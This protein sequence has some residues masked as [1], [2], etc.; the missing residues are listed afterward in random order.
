MIKCCYFQGRK[1]TEER[2]TGSVDEGTAK[3]ATQSRSS[4]EGSKMLAAMESMSF[5][6][7]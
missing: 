7:K 3:A 1:L 5:D 2:R 4:A 6:Y